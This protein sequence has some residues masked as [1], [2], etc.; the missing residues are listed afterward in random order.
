MP[1]KAQT[2]SY[3]RTRKKFPSVWCPGCSLGI[4]MGSLI[5][6]V[7]QLGL[8]QDEVVLVSG[9]GCTGRMPVYADFN[10]LHGTH[11]RALAFATGIKL[12]NPE[13]HVIAAMGDG[14]ATAIGGN[15]F[16][17]TARR[18]LDI[19][20]VIANNNIYGMTGGQYSPTTHP[21]MKATTAPYGMVE[22]P[23]DICELSRGA[24]ATYVAR[25]T[26]YHAAQMTKYFTR[27]IEK[28]GFSVV[29]VVSHCY[30]T[31]GRRN[32]FKGPVEMMRRE[33]ELSVPLAGYE[34]KKAA[35]PAHELEEGQF[36]TG[37]F[38]D[39]ERPEFSAVYADLQRR[40]GSAE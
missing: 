21:G 32:G 18:N 38:V 34:K 37:L 19:T 6:A 20:A 31:A 24:G 9:I 11:G 12:A 1:R 29:E 28:P 35:D 26:S 40:V 27:A 30:T 23:F 22:P 2:L 39:D 33:K 25:T 16:I 14:D 36:L 15:H 3:L 13:L 4:I 7:D 8:D 17:H 5:R 10:T